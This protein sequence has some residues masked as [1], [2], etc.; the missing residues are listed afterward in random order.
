MYAQ[1]FYFCSNA[2]ITGHT[3][4]SAVEKA[5]LE[6]CQIKFDRDISIYNLAPFIILFLL[7]F[8]TRSAVGEHNIL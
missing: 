3:N 5:S 8:F 2:L 7:Q 4:L 6:P 1:K